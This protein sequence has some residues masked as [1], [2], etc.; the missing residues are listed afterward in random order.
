M[1]LALKMGET[2]VLPKKYDFPA[3]EVLYLKASWP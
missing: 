3:V 1:I 2:V